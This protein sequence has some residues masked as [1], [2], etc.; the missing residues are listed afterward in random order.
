MRSAQ[1]LL[2]TYL[3]ATFET[4]TIEPMG[5]SP[6]GSAK[7]SLKST[8]WSSAPNSTGAEPGAP[9]STIRTL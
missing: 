4:T 6:A 2:K 5:T 7:S 9:I 8:A 1:G 3:S